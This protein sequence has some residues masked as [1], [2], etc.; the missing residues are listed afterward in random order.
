MTVIEREIFNRMSKLERNTNTARR[1]DMK[2]RDV[3]EIKSLTKTEE[4]TELFKNMFGDV[5]QNVYVKT[6]D[7]EADILKLIKEIDGDIEFNYSKFYIEFS[8]GTLM[9]LSTSEWGYLSKEE[10]VE[11]TEE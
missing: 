9:G 8:N 5:I 4:L 11:E 6:S 10:I 2:I 1:K 3:D 7:L